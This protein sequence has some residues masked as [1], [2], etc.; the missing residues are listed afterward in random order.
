MNSPDSRLTDLLLI[1]QSSFTAKQE[2]FDRELPLPPSWNFTF[3][4]ELSAMTVLS[5]P[6]ES[7]FSQK[8]HRLLYS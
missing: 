3:I 8:A 2:G 6:L 7:E 1:S 5:N 4:G